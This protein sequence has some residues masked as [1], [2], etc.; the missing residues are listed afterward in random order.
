MKW[1]LPMVEGSEM[2]FVDETILCAKRQRHKPAGPMRDISNTTRRWGQVAGTVRGIR[3]STGSLCSTKTLLH[4]IVHISQ[5]EKLRHKEINCLSMNVRQRQ[6]NKSHASVFNLF[7]MPK[8][9]LLCQ[10]RHF[11]LWNH[12]ITELKEAFQWKCH[13]LKTNQT[14]QQKPSSDSPIISYSCFYL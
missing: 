14:N 13:Y 7:S 5:L 6:I 4:R 9:S 12:A 11:S 10:V 3:R 1:G 8:N 2:A